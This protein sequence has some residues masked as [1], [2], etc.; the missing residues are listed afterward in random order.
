M[1]EMVL[2]RGRRGVCSRCAHGVR[3][4]ILNRGLVAV[5]LRQ[6]LGEEPLPRI[7]AQLGAM[8]AFMIDLPDYRTVFVAALDE[9]IAR[10]VGDVEDLVG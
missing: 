5:N 3:L 2:A 1:I 4:L 6:D 7:N 10:V 9:I 8:D